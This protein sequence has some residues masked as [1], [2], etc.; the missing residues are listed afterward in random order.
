MAYCGWGYDE[1][2]VKDYHNE[3]GTPLHDDKLQFEYLSLEVM[4]CGLSFS[5]VLKKRGIL[6][7]CF[8]NFDFDKVALYTQNDIERIMKTDGMIHAVRK[9]NAIIKNARAFQN[10]RKE[11]GSFDK[12]IW[13]FSGQKSILYKDHEKGLIPAQNGLS[14]KISADL[15]N[16]GFTFVGP[17]VIYSHLQAAGII[18]DHDKNCPRR[19]ELIAKYPVI[20]LEKDNEKGVKQ[21]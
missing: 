21:F 15:K 7:S 20:E 2:F 10:V 3:W 8:D 4:Q 5:T 12:Y 18:N 14:E 1:E 13:S 6:R 19:T 16:R 9:I 11:F 17:V